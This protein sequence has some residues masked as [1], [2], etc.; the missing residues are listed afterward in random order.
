MTS[1]RTFLMAGAALGILGL[2][3]CSSLPSFGGGKAKELAE[4]EKPDGSRW[5]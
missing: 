5:S 1:T 4:A 3:A 2:T